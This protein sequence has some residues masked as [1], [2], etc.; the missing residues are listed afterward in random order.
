MERMNINWKELERIAQDRVGWRMLYENFEELLN[1][2]TPLNPPDIEA[3]HTDLPINV[4][5]STTEEMRMAIK[6]IKSGKAVGPDNIP[7][8]ALK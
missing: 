8:E 3:T 5:S 2:P 7:A 6:L 4:T 1:R